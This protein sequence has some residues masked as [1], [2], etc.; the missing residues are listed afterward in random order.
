MPWLGFDRVQ[1]NKWLSRGRIVESMHWKVLHRPVELA[2]V[3]RRFQCWGRGLLIKHRTNDI[4]R[5]WL[6]AAMVMVGGSGTN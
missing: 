3:I 1:P 4:G 6:D 5:L 2:A